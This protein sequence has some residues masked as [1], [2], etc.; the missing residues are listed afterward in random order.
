MRTILIV[1]ALVACRKSGPPDADA[2]KTM[3]PEQRCE[4]TASRGTE[5]AG[6]ILAAQL[7]QLA[8]DDMKDVETQLKFPTAD[9][10]KV[11]RFMCTESSGIAEAVVT[12]WSIEGCDAFAECVVKNDRTPIMPSAKAPVAP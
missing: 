11:Y 10:D 7:H 2:F 4:A 9:D 1:A 8:G 3:T 5:C 6:A 12:C